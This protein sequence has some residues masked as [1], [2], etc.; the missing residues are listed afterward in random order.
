MNIVNYLMKISHQCEQHDLYCENCIYRQGGE[1]VP[2]ALI[3]YLYDQ[4]PEVWRK[5]KIEDIVNGIN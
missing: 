1:C 2:T 5:E 4:T 3:N